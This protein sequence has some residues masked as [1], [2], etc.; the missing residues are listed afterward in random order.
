MLVK[1]QIENWQDL[2]PHPISQAFRMMND[3]ELADLIASMKSDGYEPGQCITLYEGAILDGRNRHK[4]AIITN[5]APTF[6]EYSGSNPWGFVRWR[7]IARRHITATEKAAAGVTLH[8]ME[9]LQ[10]EAQE[11]KKRRRK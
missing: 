4:S 11:R 10:K 5:V 8:K 3:E 7:N 9:D 6:E 1:V 2:K